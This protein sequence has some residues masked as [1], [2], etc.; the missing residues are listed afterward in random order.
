MRS[1]IGM[2][3]N[4]SRFT[5]CPVFSIEVEGANSGYLIRVNY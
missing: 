5:L 4:L 1:E 2:L 3:Y